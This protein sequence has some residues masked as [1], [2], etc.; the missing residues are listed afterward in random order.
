MAAGLVHAVSR[1]DHRSGGATC[2]Y[3]SS[4]TPWEAPLP[5]CTGRSPDPDRVHAPPTNSRSTSMCA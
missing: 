1:Q 4:P 2:V 5:T 3:A